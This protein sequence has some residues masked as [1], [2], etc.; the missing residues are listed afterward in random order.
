[1]RTLINLYRVYRRV[2]LGRRAAVRM[3]WQVWNNGF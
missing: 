1:M 3:A 2:R